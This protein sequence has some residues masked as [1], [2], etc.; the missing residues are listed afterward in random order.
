MSP[1]FP[2][3]LEGFSP[4]YVQLAL[5]AC[6]ELGLEGYAGWRAA[7]RPP[8]PRVGAQPLNMYLVCTEEDI[9]R[10]RLTLY[11]VTFD[12]T[13]DFVALDRAAFDLPRAPLMKIF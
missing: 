11:P 3:H 2:H 8:A 13:R 7:A 12:L 9:K 5:R 10:V 4:E 1:L 6:L